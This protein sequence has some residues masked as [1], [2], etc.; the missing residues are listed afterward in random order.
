MPPQSS[1]HVQQN[2]EPFPRSPLLRILRY[3]LR[4]GLARSHFETGLA[5]AF[6]PIPSEAP[7]AQHA[8]HA[9]SRLLKLPAAFLGREHASNLRDRPESKIHLLSQDALVRTGP[10]DHADWNYK[11]VLGWVQRQR[12]RLALSLLPLAPI[13]RI[14]EIGYGSGIFLPELA[15]HC[16]ELHGIDIHGRNEEIAEK[17]LRQDASA[18]LHKAAA[19]AMPFEDGYFDVAVAVS[20]LEFVLDVPAASLEIA[21]VLRT[22]GSFIL[23]TPGHS[24]AADLA[25]RLVTGESAKRDYGERRESL[26]HSVLE[27]F[28]VSEKSLF[29]SRGGS[30]ISLYRGFRLTP[31]RIPVKLPV[32][33]AYPSAS[34][35]ASG[36]F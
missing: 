32:T 12:F 31:L 27:Q 29:P 28:C 9:L 19:E 36:D 21:R 17:L 2:P 16:E 6:K 26:M 11:P 13:S 1:L 22:N 20:S 5:T 18:H 15:R 23:V 34:P 35:R 10:V 3:P 30:V 25:L 14:L 33:R 7:Y 8:V 24:P 4:Y